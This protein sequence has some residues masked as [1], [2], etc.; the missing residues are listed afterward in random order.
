MILEGKKLKYLQKI[1]L[2]SFIVSCV[3]ADN[4]STTDTILPDHPFGTVTPT[5]KIPG[6]LD[7][8][9]DCDNLLS[10]GYMKFDLSKYAQGTQITE[11]KLRIHV[12]SLKVQ[13][14]YDFIY[15][16]IC[17]IPMDPITASP[18]ELHGIIEKHDELISSWQQL[19]DTGQSEY[20][21][22]TEGITAINEALSKSEEARWIAMS[23]TFE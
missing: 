14:G 9:G 1:L 20:S 6:N 15:T 22:K 12:L 2:C 13:Q 8:K 7:C 18:Q 3:F 11:A 4:I 23:Y 10:G 16:W 21:L 19:Y 5:E 17:N